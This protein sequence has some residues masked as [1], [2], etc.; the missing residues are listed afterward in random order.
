MRISLYMTMEIR[1]IDLIGPRTHS[2]EITSVFL[3]YSLLQNTT[4]VLLSLD[5]RT[6]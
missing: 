5:N 1:R 2:D 4:R 6:T 3:Y